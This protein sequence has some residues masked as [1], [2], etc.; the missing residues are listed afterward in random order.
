MEEKERTERIR[1]MEALMDRVSAA[2]ER[3]ELALADWDETR[4]AREELAAYLESPLWREDLEA[5]EA[6]LLPQELKRGVLSEDGLYD[7]LER[8]DELDDAL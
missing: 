3:L 1:R 6:G 4:P 7:L 5:D 2:A 8:A